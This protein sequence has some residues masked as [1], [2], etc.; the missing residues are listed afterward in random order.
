M[1][2]IKRLAAH[3][4]SPTL[5]LAS[6]ST[7]SPLNLMWIDVLCMLPWTVRLDNGR[8]TKSAI[9]TMSNVVR[10]ASGF[11]VVDSDVMSLDSKADRNQAALVI[12]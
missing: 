8:T 11:L 3:V 1:C 10:Y 6:N 5:G 2:Q 9:H 12:Q 7:A 4:Q